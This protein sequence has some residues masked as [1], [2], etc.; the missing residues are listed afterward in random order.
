MKKRA[1][2]LLLASTMVVSLTACGGGGDNASTSSSDTG[3]KN[4]AASAGSSS[5]DAASNDTNDTAS[6]GDA[7]GDTAAGKPDY[8][9]VLKDGITVVVNGTLTASVDNGQADFEKQWEEAVG[10][11]LTIQQLDHSGYTD[12][13]GR[14]FASQDYPDAMIMSA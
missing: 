11:D 9:E 4:D 5:N 1:L 12:A 8:H 14:L 3:T 7:S 13:V 6:S 2:S 10:I